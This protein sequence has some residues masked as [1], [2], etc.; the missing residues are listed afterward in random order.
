MLNKI[1]RYLKTLISK[2]EYLS[3]REVLIL[4]GGVGVIISII[5]IILTLKPHKLH[6]F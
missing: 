1:N 2:R 4:I 5:P 3:Y 6:F